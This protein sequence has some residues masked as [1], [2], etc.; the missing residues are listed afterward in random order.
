VLSPLG[1]VRDGWP[2]KI[3]VRWHCCAV[4]SDIRTNA[5]GFRLE[6]ADRTGLQNLGG[7]L[8]KRVFAGTEN[9]SGERNCSRIFEAQTDVPDGHVEAD[10]TRL[11]GGN[12]DGISPRSLLPSLKLDQAWHAI[13]RKEDAGEFR[14]APAGKLVGAGM[15]ERDRDGFKAGWR[16]RA[17]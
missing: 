15:Q 4:A 12:G 10:R 7:H 6:H 16:R 9:A 8:R 5:S 14:V 2:A 1:S 17:G 13:L 11:P 3:L